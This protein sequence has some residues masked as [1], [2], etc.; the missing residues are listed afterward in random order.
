ME[1]NMDF[2][3]ELKERFLRYV[4]FDTQSDPESETFPSTAKQLALLNRLVEEMISLGMTEVEIDPNGYVTGTVPATPGCESKP[5]IGFI[6]HVDTSPDMKGADIRPR[7]IERYD[8]G[9]IPLNDSLSMRVKDFPELSFFKGHT[10]IVTDGTTLL[11]ADDKAGVAEIMTALERVIASGRAHGPVAVAFTPDEETGLGIA[12]FDVEGFGAAY[13][14]TVDGGEVGELSYEN[15]NACEA[16][17][18]FR[19]VNVHPGSAKDTMVNASLLAMEYNAML[20]SAETP[21]HT[22]GYEGFFHLEQMEG[23]VAHARL[24]YIVRDHDAGRFEAR[25]DQLRHIAKVMNERWGEGAVTLTLRDQ[26]RNMKEKIAPYPFL[27]ENARAA[28]RA[29][30]CEPFDAAVR[31][32]TDGAQLCYR[33]LPCPN[34]CTGGFAFHGPFEHIA[35]EDMELCARMLEE[36]ICLPRK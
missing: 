30:G 31:G 26:Y 24:V 27:I 34:L 6:A 36:L 1:R 18:D 21:R 29:A 22:E 14:Y 23:D 7:L 11:G 17:L 25:R 9:D 2:I 32:G 16:T 3:E 13:A 35:A 4:A 12:G 20:P 19:G 10:L 8:G 15:F 28:M 33:G 5:V